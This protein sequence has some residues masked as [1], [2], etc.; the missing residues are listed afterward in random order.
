MPIVTWEIEVLIP[1]EMLLLRHLCWWNDY[2]AP[3]K[4][5]NVIIT[6]KDDDEVFRTYLAIGHWPEKLTYSRELGYYK[7]VEIEFTS[8]V[9]VVEE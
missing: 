2:Y 1:S 4:S 8:L 7:N 3:V 5:A 6:T 9:E